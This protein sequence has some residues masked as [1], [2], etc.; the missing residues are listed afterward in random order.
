MSS[1]WGEKIRISIF[2][3]SHTQAIG[4]NIEGLPPGEPVDWEEILVPPGPWAGQDR[5]HP[6]GGRYPPGA[7]RVI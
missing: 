7:V 3:G 4:V 5:H 2:G 1:S 6:Q